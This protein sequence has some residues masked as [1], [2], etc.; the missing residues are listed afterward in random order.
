MQSNNLNLDY[1]NI[2]TNQIDFCFPKLYFNPLI[3]TKIGCINKLLLLDVN[4]RNK[5]IWTLVL[6][7]HWRLSTILKASD[8]SAWSNVFW[9]M[10]VSILWKCIQY[11]I[12]RD[13]TQILRKFPSDKI[14]GKK[15]ALYFLSQPPT[16]QSF[17]FNSYMS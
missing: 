13:K 16:H 7:I 8:K 2:L 6:R 1:A 9:Y 15:N 14:N 17:T 12:R 3:W 11:T 4:W 5:A 10:K